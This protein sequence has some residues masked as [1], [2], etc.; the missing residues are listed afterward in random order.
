MKKGFTVIELVIV[1][2]VLFFVFSL[3]F[4][5][6]INFLKTY[7]SE[8]NRAEARNTVE[9]AMNKLANEFVGATAVSTYSAKSITFTTPAGVTISY[10]WS[11]VTG[12]S[13][14]RTLGASTFEAA[15]NVSNFLITYV[16][17]LDAY[18]FTLSAIS[19]KDN[20][21]ISSLIKMRNL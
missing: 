15:V 16:S 21:T 7:T 10:A 1:M 17:T 9:L 20:F 3:L 5:V 11:G 4:T 8:F 19:S 12:E 6:Y 2:A 14:I 18:N 13:L